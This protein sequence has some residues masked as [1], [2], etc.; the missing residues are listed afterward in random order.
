MY[1]TGVNRS[2][3]RLEDSQV[4]HRHMIVQDLTLIVG[5]GDI[6]ARRRRACYRTD[7]FE[8]L[9]TEKMSRNTITGSWSSMRRCCA[10]WMRGRYDRGCI[11]RCLGLAGVGGV[12][13]LRGVRFDSEAFS[14]VGWGE[15]NEPQQG[16]Q[17]GSRTL[18]C[19]ALTPTYTL[20]Q[21]PNRAYCFSP[22]PSGRGLG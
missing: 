8:Q 9:Q 15:R 4:L 14:N 3:G 10:S 2:G 20:I 16:K 1:K 7:A 12:I 19:A 11:F 6:V 22:S 17:I 13:I 5:A 18:G 21:P